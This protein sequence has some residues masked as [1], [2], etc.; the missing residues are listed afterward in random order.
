[1]PIL[2]YTTEIPVEKTIGEIQKCLIAHGANAVLTEFDDQGRVTALSFKIRIGERNMSFRLPIEWRPVLE[3]MK[4]QKEKARGRFRVALTQ[5]Q[6][7]RVAWR[8]VGAWV[9]AQMAIVEIRMVTL[10]QIFLPYAVTPD[11]KTVSERLLEG[12]GM[13]LLGP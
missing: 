3:V 5:E 9:A 11:G 12:N 4:Q 13:K 10:P 7:M 8:I 2:N 1:M 6:A